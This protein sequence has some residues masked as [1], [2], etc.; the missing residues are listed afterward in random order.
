AGNLVTFAIVVENTGSSRKGAFDVLVR[1][2]LPAG[3]RIPTALES[4]AQLNL[5][6][7]D[8]TGAAIDCDNGTGT[9]I[10]CTGGDL[11]GSGLELHDPGPTPP[12]AD[13]TNDGALDPYNATSGRNILVLTYDLIA[14]TSVQPRE[15]MTN[16]A[17]LL[18][19][20]GADDG[21][22]R[23]APTDQPFDEAEVTIAAP[24]VDKSFIA[25][26]QAFT[27][28]PDA[29]IGEIV[30]Y[31]AVITVP[32][33]TT[34]NAVLVDV[35][36]SGLAFVDMVGITASPGVSTSVVGGFPA[37]AS[38]VAVANVDGGV[39]NDGRR[40]TL[41]F[42]T[43]TNANTN[44]AVPETIT[45]TYRAV[46]LNS[47]NNNRGDQR[48]NLA[49]WRWQDD[50][51]PQ[52]VQDSASDVRIV[53]P[54]LAV[55]KDASPITGQAGDTITFTIEVR[56]TLF[57]N[58]DAF[59]VVL[60]DLIP[61]RMTYV[62]GSLSN[63]SG[64]VPTSLTESLGTITVIWDT[65]PDNS[66]SFLTFNATLDF[67][68]T[69]GEVITNNAAATWTS[70]PGN[71]T[72]AQ[73][74]YNTLSTERT[75]DPANPGGAAN[76]YR[77]TDPAS[78]TIIYPQ[79]LEKTIVHTSESFTGGAD[80]A[81]GE[82]VRYRLRA[83]LIEGINPNYT[84]VDRLQNGLSFL[85]LSQVKVSFLSNT[86]I[87]APPDMWGANV[88]G[89]PPTFV[90]PASRITV[91]GQQVTF[92]F[93]TLVDT[94][95]DAGDEIVVLEF[96]ALV[97]NTA[98]TNNGNN[99]SNV[100]DLRVG[101][102]LIDTSDPINVR[103]R[104]PSIT[105]LDKQVIGL[106]PV[107]AGD[108]VTYR[109]TYSNTGTTDAFDVR[110][111]DTLN[112]T[113]LA[114]AL[115]PAI[116]LAGGAGLA[117]DNSVGNTLDV[118]V[119][120]VPVGGSVTIT[121][122]ATLTAAVEP[123]LVIP[124]TANLTYTSLPG[125][126]GTPAG[127]ENLTGSSTP[128]ASGASDGERNGSGGVN[129]YSDTDSEN[130][131]VQS[132][133][134]AKT[135]TATNQVHT[136]GLEVA[137]GEI[138]TYEA[139]ITVPE[140]TMP[141]AIVVDTPDAGLAIVAVDSITRSNPLALS[142]SVAG[143]FPQVL[144][145]A[146]ASIPVSGS[147][148]TL[149]FG[150]LTNTNTNNA[151]AETITVTYRA[152]VLNTLANS[153]GFSLDN[154]ARLTWSQG[155]LT[156][157][158]D[159]VTIVEP[160]L[161][162]TKQNGDPLVGDAGDVITF[163]I[164]VQHTV[165][166]DADAFDVQLIDLIN[167]MVTGKMT[168]VPNSVA[169]IDAGG[170]TLAPGSPSQAGGDL[171]ITWSS[172]PLPATSTITF[173]VTLDITVNPNE[174]LTNTADL[175]WTGLP[176][177]VTVPQSSNPY[178]VERTG[179][180]A[181]PG[182][183]GA[184]DYLAS[185]S[186]IVL[187]P[188]IAASKEILDT[189]EPST[190]TGEHNPAITDLTIGETVT[191]GIVVNFI[192]GTTDNVVITDQLPF[193]P[194][195]LQY[196]SAGLAFVGADLTAGGGGPVT[197]PAPVLTDT[198]GDGV[199]DRVVL[200][201]G[202]IVN[203]ADVLP[204]P[205][206][207][208]Q[209]VVGI[210]ARVLNLLPAPPAAPG[211]EANQDGMLL[212]NTATVTAT[213]V[214]PLVDIAQVEV[215]EPD[216]NVTKDAAP[217]VVDGGD[218]VTFT[219]TVNHTAASTADAF[220][221]AITD[222]L[223]AGLTYAGN[224]IPI[225]GSGPAVSVA[226]QTVTFFWTDIPLGAVPYTFTFDV[227]VDATITP[228][229]TFLNVADLGWSTLPGPNPN[230]RTYADS[231]SAE[232]V[233]SSTTLRDPAKSLVVTSESS[234]P[235]AP[236]PTLLAI[237]EIVR[238]RLQA[239]LTEG[240]FPNLTFVDTLPLGMSFLDPS[241]V[242]VSFTSNTAMGLAP[243]L[244]GANNGAIPPTF[245]LPPGRISLSGQQVTFDL[246]TV[247]NNDNDA[248]AEL[249]TLEFNVLVDNTVNDNAG[250]VKS[251]AFQAFV[252]GVQY[253]DT[254][255][256]PVRLVE[257]LI[258]DVAKQFVSMSGNQRTFQVSFSNTGTTTAFD[259]L[260]TDVIPA[261]ASLNV[262]PIS[263]A[264]GGGATG[265]STVGSTPGLLQV[266]I[267]EIPVGGTV[268][269]QYSVTLT[270][271]SQTGLLNSVAV[272]TTSLPGLNGTTVNPTG[273]STP[274]AP[275]A[276]N[277][278]RT[279][280]G[281]VNDLADADNETLGSL[282]DL[283]WYDLN[284]NGVYNSGE[285]G[286]PNVDMTAVWAGPDGSLGTGDDVTLTTTT[287]ASGIYFFNAL[288]PGNY[289]VSVDT[290]DIPA[291]LIPSFDLDGT[292]DSTTVVLL[293]TGQ[294]RVDVD[295][296]YTDPSTIT[297]VKY[298]DTNGNGVRDPGEGPIAN[299]RI[300]IDAN[301]NRALDAGERTTVTD[302]S[303]SYTLG[304]L[305]PG[306]YIVRELRPDY[307][308]QT[309]PVGDGSYTV[310]IVVPGSI[311]ADTD[312]G[313]HLVPPQII[314][315]GDPDFVIAGGWERVRCWI[316][317]QS[318]AHYLCSPTP[319]TGSNYVQWNF[320]GLASGGTYQVST[321]WAPASGLSPNAL[322]TVTGGAVPADRRLDQRLP[323]SAYPGSFTADGFSWVDVD[324]SY[325]ISGT[326]LSVRLSDDQ[327]TGC[328]LADAVRIIQVTT[329]EI[330]VQDG[331]AELIDNVSTVNLGSTVPGTPLYRTFTVSNTGG[332]D[333]NL[334]VI[335]LP[336]GFSLFAPLGQTV[337]APDEATTFTVQLGAV[338]QG[339]YTGQV[340]LGNNDNDEAPFTFNIVGAVVSV[341]PA[342][343]VPPPAPV[344]APAP[345]LPLIEVRD[346][347]S[348][349][350]S[351]LS[352]IDFGTTTVGSAANRVLTVT[353]RGAADLLLGTIVVPGPGFGASPLGDA[354]LSPG[355]S[356]TFTVSLIAST[357]GTYTGD[358]VMYDAASQAIFTVGLAGVVN[359]PPALL[360]P[361]I[362]DNG[363]GVAGF[364]VSGFTS[365]SSTGF[366]GD[367]HYTRGDA[368]GD[369]ATWVFGGLPA[370]EYRV[371]VT[372]VRGSS[373]ATNAP[374]TLA[375][376]PGGSQTVLV[377]QQLA[378]NDRTD[379]GVGWKDLGVFAVSGGALSVR[380]T[381][382]ANGY[383]YADA[384]RV[385]Q[386]SGGS[387]PAPPAP[388]PPPPPL[389]A[390]V[391]IDNGQSVAGFSASGLT[392]VTTSGYQGDIQYTRGD[393]TGDYA[394]WTFSGLP[395]GSYRISTTWVKGTSRAS[396][397]AYTLTGVNG[398]PANV[399]RNQQVAPD[400]LTWDG[401]VWEDLGTFQVT[402]GT[403]TV[404]LTDNANGYVYADAVRV[405]QLSPLEAVGVAEFGA[406][407]PTPPSARGL[408]AE[409]VELLTGAAVARWIAADAAAEQGGADV[410]VRV[411]D[412]PAGVLG[413][414]AVH[415]RTIWV[416]V[417]AD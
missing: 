32:E 167:T 189:S 206:A 384:V 40:I 232:V 169:V 407:L 215:V 208:D 127:L 8:G 75:G 146:N 155:T 136:L 125:P 409:A 390:P 42:G 284:G 122:A 66:S 103:I 394:Q 301:D 370:G 171:N 11:F 16:T 133:A 197:L 128:G 174:I 116:G 413:L 172:F 358:L 57:S 201:L 138:V 324:S 4:A 267:D 38:G 209:M 99:R 336:D 68:V 19:F 1:D 395:S 272:T 106:P 214:G 309:E 416:D 61:A 188:T 95:N 92:N 192:D 354:V 392:Y 179:D 378:P 187:T 83:T 88:G 233:S 80:V 293:G 356:A 282:G 85:D 224:V 117:H 385:E 335:T 10:A 28:D 377:N 235:D 52:N 241:Q 287:D 71:V 47:S 362:L 252:D 153:R 290:A 25:T 227:T 144:V 87:G 318:D 341:S 249:V 379:R 158:A 7:R 393:N 265:A 353:N 34:S 365:S 244:A 142:T 56:H 97:R 386:L 46:V 78:V 276:P 230:E 182:Q 347:A 139:V 258:A 322:F 58:A 22:N 310:V 30:T 9:I 373:R 328:L 86:P 286:L 31:Q 402:G 149:N 159:P 316:F 326:T 414:A 185:D 194:G 165:D 145:N 260:V 184:N 65:F 279:G 17:T 271:A 74:A 346:G 388:P 277:G 217:P 193:A 115:P 225:T 380:L 345:A 329:P 236:P 397:A 375:G 207:D 291:P 300:Y 256:V 152:V 251:N 170:A 404:R 245:V 134:F 178:S 54:T 67:T 3:F 49:D 364:T 240:R 191:F 344:P 387:S 205:N 250:D 24:T 317:F 200:N 275:G 229:Q 195:V 110:V 100:F 202:T 350:V 118:S 105:N 6:V 299:V 274:G 36:D 248:S 237:G 351:G 89:L 269:I 196:V 163:E 396:N 220:D 2:T 368:S 168:Y 243:D 288:P 238:Y 289:R 53:E 50:F 90:M 104:E 295:F 302:A 403:L 366:Q 20:A 43:V 186:G 111:V 79:A 278:E 96:N 39:I 120:R 98:A 405:E 320:S 14:D 273:S 239:E 343:T 212:T 391:V 177:N 166:S 242:R 304:N 60:T 35:L 262:G 247:T 64:V 226:G 338:L 261:G 211:T 77:A 231:D 333:L 281:G 412:L 69:P 213:G 137:I 283:V 26:N 319:G 59:N 357:A 51:G 162:I 389:S 307:T 400:D 183:P 296:G 199:I 107:D 325:A 140:G 18:A 135:L 63:T 44:D 294:D 331:G 306:T 399:L 160:T 406:G 164:L 12:T 161:S 360:P 73:S 132:P 376:V 268:L 337:L 154:A 398:G 323:P 254:Q 257:P 363:V 41:N 124:N 119:D 37:V 367:T 62:G 156:D 70:L 223:P 114:L 382:A 102:N 129:D 121:Y 27:A 150:T 13:G 45:V 93:G 342:P 264:L 334:G 219:M 123:S 82:I 112:S 176:G 259:T 76:D 33:G 303:G 253:G 234:T 381:D 372:Y 327:T 108:P 311:M 228:G 339:V 410:Q 126:N 308:I 175:N 181:G 141:N 48:N 222:V 151:V 218:T 246:G 340:T 305:L 313:N 374:Y 55:I 359:A 355:E 221:V 266:T 113:Y 190:D 348:P 371:S 332:D 314:D 330:V 131:T 109:V 361:L 270:A 157:T 101:G 298:S 352:G 285:P 143:G 198:N 204:N 216:L 5:Q 210:T 15:T 94:D 312:F 383:V 173:Q 417:D 91:A 369:A 130:V 72:I 292:L 415:S 315:N 349:L 297:G 263:V 29:A 180:P 84:F 401:T 408:T 81:I 23:V 203:A 411:D 148:V 21:D 321:T 147:S 280:A 255:S